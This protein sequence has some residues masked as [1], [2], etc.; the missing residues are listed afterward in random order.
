MADGPTVDSCTASLPPLALDHLGGERFGTVL[1]DPPWRF[2]NRTGKVAPEH[3]R[4]SR[5]DTMKWEE[6]AALPVSDLMADK[7]HC[8]LW[9]PNALI[10]DCLLYTSDA[11]D[12][13][14]CV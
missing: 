5:Y 4:L 1:A 6:I 14:L 3:K 8:Y 2:M 11:A 13:L 9:V 10:A 7:S 12:D